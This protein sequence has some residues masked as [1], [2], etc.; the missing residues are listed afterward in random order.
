MTTKK[1]VFTEE[2]RQRAELV[3]RIVGVM[4]DNLY[5]PVGDAWT[6][7]GIQ[8]TAELIADLLTARAA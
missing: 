7:G 3:Q 2:E 8:G 5:N 6:V 4:E 1:K